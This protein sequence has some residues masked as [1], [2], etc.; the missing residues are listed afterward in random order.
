MNELTVLEQENLFGGVIPAILMIGLAAGYMYFA[1][2]F[3]YNLGKD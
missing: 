2:D 1:L 3:S